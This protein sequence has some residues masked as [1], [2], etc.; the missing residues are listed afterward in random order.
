MTG[1]YSSHIVILLAITVTFLI[2]TTV[3][4]HREPF[5]VNC[6]LQFFRGIYFFDSFKK[7][8]FGTNLFSA[9]S[10]H[11]SDSVYFLPWTP[12]ILS[13]VVRSIGQPKSYWIETCSLLTPLNCVWLDVC[14]AQI[15]LVSVPGLL[16]SARV[17]LFVR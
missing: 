15:T 17:L 8:V 12:L 6:H 5:T 9:C 7:S 3:S 16:S 2:P 1:T 10:V 11:R 4:G 14:I 13:K